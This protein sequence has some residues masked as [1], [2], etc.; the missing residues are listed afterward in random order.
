MRVFLPLIALMLLGLGFTF[1]ALN[2]SPVLLDFFG[3]S[4]NLRL[5]LALILAALLGALGAGFLLALLVIWPQQ[6]RLRRVGS[7][8]RAREAASASEFERA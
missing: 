6:R 4:V 8:L 7:Q 1:G 2:P 5:G 3:L